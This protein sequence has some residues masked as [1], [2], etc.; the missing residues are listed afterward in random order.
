MSNQL[1][2]NLKVEIDKNSSDESIK[3]YLDNVQKNKTLGIKIDTNSLAEQI[4]NLSNVTFDF[5]KNGV[6]KGLTYQIKTENGE[7][8]KIKQQLNKANEFE[9]RSAQIVSNAQKQ[10]MQNEELKVKHIQ[11]QRQLAI[12]INKLLNSKNGKYISSSEL[13]RLQ[14]L[15]KSFKNLNATS[16]KQL[17]SSLKDT[18]L[19]INEIANNANNRRLTTTVDKVNSLGQSLKNLGLYVSGA[20][21]VRKLFNEFRDAVQHI[22]DVDSAFTNMSMT[23][24]SL[25]K[26]QFDEMMT[27]IN[28]M[29]KEM[30]AVSSDVLKI[31]QT[32]ANDS[33]SIE[34]VMNKLAPS[35]ALMN[36]SGM[37]ATDVTKSIMSIANSY[38]MLEEGGTNAAEVTEYL[39]D[40]LA[41]VSA[42]M[43]MDFQEGLQGLVSGI[44]VAGSTM[45]AAGV[46]MEWFVGQLG[47]AMV[48]TGQTADKLGRG[49]RTITARVM[50]QK[51]AL[52]ELGESTENIELE[53]AK[54]EKALKELGIT[55]RNDTTGQL[56]S[57]SSIMDELGGRWKGLSD[58][59]KYYLAE[60]LAGKNQMDI[61]IGMMDSYENALGLVS[62]AYEAQGTLMDM[63]GEYADS[64]QGKL[65]TLTSTF[66]EL[67]QNTIN[68]DGF[69][70]LID[71]F[72][73]LISGVNSFVKTVGS[74]PT[75]MGVLTAS[76]VAFTKE[77]HMM[78]NMLVNIV[79]GLIGY[80]TKTT[81]ATT[82]TNAS[83][84]A[85][86]GLK[87]EIGLLQGVMT[88]G[89]S[90][91]IGV[92]V[93]GLTHLID[94]MKN[95]SK[96]AKEMADEISQSFSDID[97]S[98][99]KTQNADSLIRQYDNLTNKMNE[100][101]LSTQELKV[102]SE[103]LSNVKSKLLELFPTAI[104][105]Y[106]NEGNAIL[107]NK[108]NLEKL[109]EAEKENLRIQQEALK[110]KA[111]A[112]YEDVARKLQ[113][114]E[115]KKKDIQDKI[116]NARKQS[117]SEDVI[118]SDAGFLALNELSEE[119]IAIQSEISSYTG[120]LKI[121]D[122][123]LGKTKEQQDE[124]KESTEEMA[125]QAT[126]V[127]DAFRSISETAGG[128]D[129]SNIENATQEYVELANKARNIQAVIDEINKNG[130]HLDALDSAKEYMAGFTG[131]IGNASDVLKHLNE[132]LQSTNEETYLL[133]ANLLS[134]DKS[135]WESANANSTEYFNNN[136][137]NTN[138]W[139]NFQQQIYNQLMKIDAIMNESKVANYDGYFSH[140]AK[141]MQTELANCKSL[142]EAKVKIETVATEAIMKQH[143]E[144]ANAM[145][146]YGGYYDMK[147][148]WVETS[149]YH[150]F[151]NYN[152]ISTAQANQ[153]ISSILKWKENA[154]ASI[155]SMDALINTA[156]T[157]TS[158][159]GNMSDALSGA[160]KETEKLVADLEDIADAYYE[161]N[162][163][164]KDVEN[165]LNLNKAKQE[166]STGR[167][168]VELMR[169]EVELLKK[170]QRLLTQQQAEMGKERD[171]LRK[172]LQNN[173]FSFSDDG[174]ITNYQKR[175]KELQN[176]ANS[177]SGDNKENAIESVEGLV[178]VIERYTELIKD[179]IPNV[180]Q[181]WEEMTTA[182]KE[183]EREQLDYVTQV[184]KDIT[185]A[186]ENELRKRTDAVKKELQK[187][188]DLYNSQY[189]EE[190]WNRELSEGQRKIDEIKAQINA[191]SRD[192][193]LAGQ[194]KLEQLKNDLIEQET[195]FNDMIREHEKELG[196]NR[197]DEEISN[198]ED[199]LEEQLTSEN[200]ASLVNQALAT[201]F[202]QIGDSVME[203]DTLMTDW[204]DD[205]GDGLYA[206][207]DTLKSELIDQLVIAKE[208]MS[209]IGI[210]SL[211][212]NAGMKSR[213]IDASG[214]NSSVNLSIGNLLNIDGNLTE[215]LLPEVEVMLKNASQELLNKISSQLSFR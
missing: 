49:M 20:M 36:I 105:G 125:N 208:L 84:V 152:G 143:R 135:Y 70:G 213:T 11:Q 83:T 29:S 104:D 165:A 7:I 89:L 90:V 119:L 211:S 51:Q 140:V 78:R 69:K 60:Q 46:D 23:M 148:D 110:I 162:N 172:T 157:F 103:E 189:D 160:S 184:Q 99:Q 206:V 147:G 65:N 199:A 182:I 6:L 137:K 67:Y 107:T 57:F 114:A 48:A 31:A 146:S 108:E 181:S 19:S 13:K 15:E 85:T 35:T 214:I 61:F 200:L 120:T 203:L 42:N 180:V 91:A 10:Q 209:H 183:A 197:F 53:F 191:L 22:K 41:K 154:L 66:Q 193:S 117:Q 17:N 124:V 204:L 58:S 34:A 94:R 145:K 86:R 28:S 18:K 111:E 122:D 153:A 169:E 144:V 130:V 25:T 141:N 92:I 8:L 215:D 118:A 179:E 72:T 38:Q 177:L 138:E 151:D 163:A 168:R 74:V 71:G 9:V 95:S 96:Y 149:E 59:T 175:L 170:K 187:Q 24:E 176:W 128:F 158:S 109:N 97:S 123:V 112:N 27:K 63:N 164:L 129:S 133:Y 37:G 87:L 80:A 192:T 68:T 100:G 16:T 55:I 202:V 171:A 102:V 101:K 201:G 155:Q 173:G 196:N 43:D 156:P 82:V 54:G 40:V 106:D 207:G 76:F 121:Y 188:Q 26:N 73:S 56:K 50:Q 62:N 1:G 134:Y 98:I 44:G 150:E 113:E 64:L 186:I 178:D 126:V 2:I 52:E 45:K 185:S 12:E 166:N 205:F 5:D 47:N 195:L 127:A 115:K 3:R 210:T 136:I 194:L 198:L 30:G 132:V 116:E 77:G 142:A 21:I 174:S 32:F 167:K 212:N 75:L 33:T 139:A 14:D 161:I 79:K 39:G 88:M 159:I 93:G 190:D 81:T 131:N 4:K